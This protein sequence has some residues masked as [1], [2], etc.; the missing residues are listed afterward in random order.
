MRGDVYKRHIENFK[1]HWWF[2]GRKKIIEVIL[3]RNK[4]KKKLDILDFG[5]GSGTNLKMLSK[6]GKVYIYEPHQPTKVF[7]KNFG[8]LLNS[9]FSWG[10]TIFGEVLRM[11]KRMIYGQEKYW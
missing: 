4:N 7:L 8:V 1:D 11:C 10:R 5:T 6:F 2:Q 9:N 3:K